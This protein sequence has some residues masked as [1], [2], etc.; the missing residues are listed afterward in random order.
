[1]IAEK[2]PAMKTCPFCDTYEG[3]EVCAGTV[4]D[5]DLLD[6]SLE[7]WVFC[8]ECSASGP[9]EGDE[10]QSINTWNNGTKRRN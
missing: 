2:L 1:M 9:V 5:D 6:S 4:T 3:L 10:A 8:R 7:F